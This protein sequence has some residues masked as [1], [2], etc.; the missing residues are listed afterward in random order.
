MTIASE[1]TKLQTN[2]ANA[3][4]KCN[5]KGAT[6]PA[7]QNFD[8][9][10]NCID[11]IQSGG[12]STKYFGCTAETFL[13]VVDANGVLQA[14][15]SS[16]YFDN[17][18]FTGVIN[19]ADAGLAAKFYNIPTTTGTAPQGLTRGRSRYIKSLSFPD[20]EVLSNRYSLY[21]MN[22]A[23]TT[24]ES[25]S[26]PKLQ[27]ISGELTFSS[28][29]EECTGL[30]SLD[31][32]SLTTVSGGSAMTSAFLHCTSLTSVDLSSLTTLSGSGAMSSAFN[33]CT[34]LTS[35]DLSS[36]INVGRQA[37]LRTF[38]NCT[39]LSTLSFP[40]LTSTSFG[41]QTNQFSNMLQGVTGCTVH[42][43]SN[44]QSVIGSW[45][46]VTAGFGGSS[47]TVLFDLPA[48]T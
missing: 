43:P 23:N 33:N 47:T 14:P 8:N 45:G 30:T 25:A 4:S 3:Y 15:F 19:I 20:L 2:L 16:N 48:T 32:S 37:M 11:T 7:S 5:D 9:L 18:V 26:F 36:L 35:V 31:L 39:S 46:D 22:V 17:I 24:L 41:T 10:A 28:A 21:G 27:T 1:I 42:F 44:L 13:G 6:I 34:G 29:F 38:R 40:S 12:G